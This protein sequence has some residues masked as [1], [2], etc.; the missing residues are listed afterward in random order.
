MWYKKYVVCV[1]NNMNCVY[2]FYYLKVNYVMY[3]E[4]KVV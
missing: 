4:Y 2:F 3:F 1:N